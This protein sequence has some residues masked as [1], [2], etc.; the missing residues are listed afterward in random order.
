MDMRVLLRFASVLSLGLLVF[1]YA[2]CKK[3]DNGPDPEEKMQ[4]EKLAKTWTISNASLDGADRTADFQSPDFTLT[5]SGSFNANQP[6]GPYLYTVSGNRPDPS[7]WPGS[8]PWTFGDDPNTQLIRN[9]DAAGVPMTYSIDGSGV[10]TL[11]FT[12]TNCN[13]S[14]TGRVSEVNGNWQFVLNP[15]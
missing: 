3:K 13:Y 11:S 4:L 8:G 14:S 5:I 7:P 9:D 10:L 2:G 12:C 15:Q 6:K 1:F